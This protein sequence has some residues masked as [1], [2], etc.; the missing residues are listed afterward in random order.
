KSLGQWPI[1]R[2]FHESLIKALTESG[3]RMIIF[4]ILLSEQS[5]YDNDLKEAMRQS[6][7]VYLPCAFELEEVKRNSSRQVMAQDIVG[8]VAEPFKAAAAGVGH[9][10]IIVDTDGKVRRLPLWVRYKDKSWPY[11]GF[12]AAAK[13]LGYSLEQEEALAHQALDSEGALWI[14]YPGPWTSTFQHFSYLEVLKAHAAKKNGNEPSVDLSVLKDKICFVGLTATGTV[15][16]K[17]TPLDNIYPMVGAQASVCDSIL[18]G[19]FIRRAHPFVRGVLA[20]GI[21]LLSSLICLKFMPRAAFFYSLSLTAVYSFGAWFLFA[22]RGI[23]LDLFFP[24]TGITLIY[25]VILLMKFFDEIQKRRLLEKELEIAASIQ[26]SFLPPEVHTL[27]DIQVR[28]FL[29]PA[30]FIGGDFYDII[31]LDENTFGFFIADVS[32]KG[33]S[34]ALLMA[35]AIS[36]LRQVGRGV[37][38]PSEAL[39][40]LNNHLYPILKG[41][42]VTGQYLVVHAAEGFWEGSCAG[43]MPLFYFD[44]AKDTINELLEASGPPLGLM[45]N[46]AYTVYRH[47]FGLGDK[48]FMYTDGWTEAR[49]S[50]GKEFGVARL[51]EA[52]MKY[53]KEKIN[54][55]FSQLQ[56]S[57]TA[58]E[59]QSLQHD[60]VTA[61]MLEF[62]GITRQ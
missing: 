31:L 5:Q 53:R 29:K 27:A 32:G 59:K 48:L 8:A 1:P 16:L 4:D 40:L 57:H 7:N 12:L 33:V 62:P 51:K 23:F 20:L 58:F 14:N 61:L 42:F 6:A 30:K 2:N 50:K 21:F 17:P 55:I 37:Y 39:R 22:F 36:L 24:L 26:Q 10:N 34:A 15:D 25:T 46:V 9:I 47:P 3:C 56:A 45:E 49:D 44:S 28:T 11:L 41:R 19:A 54:T 52:F 18:R 43:H 35:Q 13:R 60:D 38:D